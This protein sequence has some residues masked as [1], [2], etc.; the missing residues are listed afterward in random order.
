MY[1]YYNQFMEENVVQE[2]VVTRET[3]T[4][5]MQTNTVRTNSYMSDFFVSKIN[6]V[7]IGI[8]TIIN[9]LI[10]LRFL[11]SLLGANRVGF[12]SFIY[13]LTE[14]FVAPFRGVFP[15][16]TTGESFFDMASILAIIIWTV[17]AIIFGIVVNM[18]S[19]KA[20]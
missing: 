12:V 3:P 8:V 17:L 13:V 4:G 2:T 18:F 6:Q 11:F 16:P 19:T 14:L 15:S 1:I 10:A 5:R 7:I 20:E 9:I